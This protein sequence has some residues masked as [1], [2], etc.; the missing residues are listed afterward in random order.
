MQ[1]EFFEYLASS[2]RYALIPT[3]HSGG[4]AEGGR[5]GDRPRISTYFG[6]S[7]SEVGPE[8]DISEG[9]EKVVEIVLL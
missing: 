9:V 4:T 2:S 1:T 7:V 6:R 3:M 5:H 8:M